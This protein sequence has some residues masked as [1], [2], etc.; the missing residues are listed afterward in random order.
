M[1]YQ[2]PVSVPV[3]ASYPYEYYPEHEEIC[4]PPPLILTDDALKKVLITQIEY[5]FSDANLATGKKL[6]N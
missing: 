6:I 1:Y 5:Y 3:E 4:T 2:E